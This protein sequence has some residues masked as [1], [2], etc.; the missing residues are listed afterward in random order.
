M[1][2]RGWLAGAAAWAGVVTGCSAQPMTGK[3]SAMSSPL[4]G[5]SQ[6]SPP[7]VPPLVH[8]GVRYEQDRERQRRT[9]AQRGGWLLAFDAATG[10][11]LWGV[12]VYA[13][14]YDVQ[15]PTGSPARWFT[16][17]RLTDSSDRIEIV[18]SVGARFEVDLK[19]RAVTQT[20]DP[21]AGKTRRSDNRP[22]FE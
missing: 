11:R 14:P 10:V 5:S 3:E 21:F 15:A 2:R 18:D 12:Q 1:R 20:H 4:G 22:K 8:A 13:N 9:D 16:S 19:S 17:M 7:D 6:A